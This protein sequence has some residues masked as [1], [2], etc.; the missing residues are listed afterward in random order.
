[1]TGLEENDVE[2]TE[3]RTYRTLNRDGQPTLGMMAHPFD[4][5]GRSG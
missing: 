1:M 3:E 5:S 2:A 4:E